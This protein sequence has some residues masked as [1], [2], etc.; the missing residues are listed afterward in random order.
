MGSLSGHQR[1]DEDVPLPECGTLSELSFLLVVLLEWLWVMGNL[2]SMH[3]CLISA[4]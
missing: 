3:H 2:N 1:Q 4:E